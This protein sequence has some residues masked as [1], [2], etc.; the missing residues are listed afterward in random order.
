MIWISSRIETRPN[1]RQYCG[2]VDN[3]NHVS[4]ISMTYNLFFQ[5]LVLIF[6]TL[7]NVANLTVRRIEKYFAIS[8]R[9]WHM[10]Y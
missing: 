2:G 8:V 3:V 5:F 10:I 1:I 7:G 4:Q 9:L 6:L